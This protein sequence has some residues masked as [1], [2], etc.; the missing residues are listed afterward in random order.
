MI[1]KETNRTCEKMIE[2]HGAFDLQNS[3]YLT[4]QYMTEQGRTGH[5]KI[6]SVREREI[7][8]FIFKNKMDI[9]VFFI[10]VLW[11]KSCYVV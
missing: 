9:F 6:I 10:I 8:F 5:N 3:K 2:S 11:T 4:E 1:K 7:I